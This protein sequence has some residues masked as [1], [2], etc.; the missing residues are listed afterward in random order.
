MA[1]SDP[2]RPVPVQPFL[3]RVQDAVHDLSVLE[4]DD[5]AGRETHHEGGGQDVLGARKQ[6]VGNPV[7][8]EPRNDAAD[9]AHPEEQAGNLRQIP[10]PAG[11]AHDQHDDSQ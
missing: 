2:M 3:H 6:L 1:V 10:V 4:Q 9:D 11:H 5:D 7:G 8:V